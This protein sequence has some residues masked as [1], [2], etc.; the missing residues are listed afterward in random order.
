MSRENF[1][2]W[3]ELVGLEE[4]NFPRLMQL[5]GENIQLARI[6]QRRIQEILKAI[7][8]NQLISIQVQPG[9]GA[10]TLYRYMANYS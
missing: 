5:E 7:A 4:Y 6:G 1:E 10:T 9:W 3:K 8:T 2:Y